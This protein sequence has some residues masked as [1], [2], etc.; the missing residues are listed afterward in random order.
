MDRLK[1]RSRVT[2][3]IAACGAATLGCGGQ[4][5]PPSAETIAGCYAF[6]RRDGGR[7]A[8]GLQLPDTLRLS[9][10]VRRTPD[11]QPHPRFSLELE[12]VAQRPGG[13]R[14]SLRLDAGHVV[15]G[16]PG[17]QEYYSMKGWRFS[18]PDSVGIILHANMSNSWELTLRAVGDSLI[19]SAIE[20]SDVVDGHPRIPV[21][22]HRT[23]CADAQ[24]QRAAI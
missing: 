10:T 14:D 21:A 8:L 23:K 17:W 15:P 11:D 20:Y 4:P 9:S 16:P 7:E 6:V 1:R 5:L 13:G 22:G 2:L 18:E 24:A 19:G 3:L 12:V